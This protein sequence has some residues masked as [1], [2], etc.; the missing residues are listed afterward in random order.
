ML[1]FTAFAASRNGAVAI[2]ERGAGRPTRD[3]RLRVQL[4][5]QK[6]KKDAEAKRAI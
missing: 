1:D 3:G 2:P 6:F 4:F 5:S